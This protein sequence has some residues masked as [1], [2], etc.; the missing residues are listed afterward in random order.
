M[1][2]GRAPVSTSTRLADDLTLSGL[3]DVLDRAEAV[4]LR[5]ASRPGRAAV[6]RAAGRGP[7]LRALPVARP[8][9]VPRPRPIVADRRVAEP[10][11]AATPARRPLR[12]RLRALARRLA[13]WGAGSDGEYLAWGRPGAGVGRDADSPVVLTELPSTPTIQ[14]AASSPAAAL[15]PG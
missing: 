1:A 12:E 8:I 15:L 13:L 7:L 3:L 4:P 5:H 6:Y 2:S 11:P 10:E 9:P 14:P